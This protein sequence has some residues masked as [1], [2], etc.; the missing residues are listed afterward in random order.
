MSRRTAAAS[1]SAR[2]TCGSARAGVHEL[3]HEVPQGRGRLCKQFVSAEASLVFVHTEVALLSRVKGR[4]LPPPS[5][6][7]GFRRF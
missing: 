3:V 1:E 6:I 5:E 7:L 4:S 2:R